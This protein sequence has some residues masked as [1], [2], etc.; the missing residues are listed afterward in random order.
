[1][2]IVDGRRDMQS[3]LQLRL[4]ENKRKTWFLN[5]YPEAGAGML[6]AP[7]Y[8]GSNCKFEPAAE[9]SLEAYLPGF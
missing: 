9:T 2:L 8:F 1:L 6:P 3:L 5:L 7:K 4:L